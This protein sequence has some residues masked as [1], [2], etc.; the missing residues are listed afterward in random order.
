MK[1]ERAIRSAAV[2]LIVCLGV[3]YAWSTFPT[4]REDKSRLLDF[5]EF[6]AA[7]KMV[8]Q[9]LGR[10]LYDL[11]L[12][13][14]FQL[15]VAPVHAFYLRP[16]FEALLFVPYTYLG[17][18]SAYMA[19]LIT[20]LVALLVAAWLI[21]NHSN[22]LE[23]MLQYTH[24]IPVDFGLLFILFLTFGPTMNCLLI[25]QDAILI[26][27]I[28]T[29]TFRALKQGRELEAGCLLACGLFKYHLVL[30][31]AIIFAIRRRISFLTGFAAVVVALVA[32]SMLIS[33]PEVLKSYPTM[34]INP[35][36]RRLMSFQ[37]EYAA[38]IHGLVYLLTRDKIPV[39]ASAAAVIVLSLALLW[40][41]AGKWNDSQFE[42]YFS[43]AVVATVLTGFHAFVYDLTLL[44]LPIA[45]ACGELA[46]Q[47]ELFRSSSFNAAL[48]ILF[49]PPAHNLLATYHIYALMGLVLL[50]LFF[51]IIR[52]ISRKSSSQVL[53]VNA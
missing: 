25:G 26:L 34:F 52:A 19:W 9:G 33:G 41:T 13:A 15:E 40:F 6:Y 3:R 7:A 1:R 28:Y 27:I 45:I 20:S 22:V 2:L 51:T 37:P 4:S 14:E 53:S 32:L 47:R 39:S 50:V 23:A 49:L 46:K 44:L 17:Y 18:R 43:A 12:Q 5:S 30:P 24:G 42:L 16:P 38:N 36:Y 21:H 11:K 29:A 35:G 8:R 48:L 10:S 31:F